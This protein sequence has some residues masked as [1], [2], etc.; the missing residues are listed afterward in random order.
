MPSP[1]GHALGGLIVGLLVVPR[2]SAP[3]DQATAVPGHPRTP[4]PPHSGTLAPR[5]L[6]TLAPW[7][8]RALSTLAIVACLPDLDFLWGRHGAETHSLGAALIAAA[9]ALV[10]T[11]GGNPWLAL[12]VGLAW[13]SHPLFDWLGSDDTPPLGVMALWPFTHRYY[14]A[15]AFV[16]DAISRRD[17]LPGFWAHNIRAVV[18]EALLLAPAVLVAGWLRKWKVKSK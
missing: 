5:H 3:P 15:E 10:W 8:L 12:A 6:G 9:V 1:I 17:W 16:F 2:R 4:A 13:A 11:R 18:R 7:R 14:F